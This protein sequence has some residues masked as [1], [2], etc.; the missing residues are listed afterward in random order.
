MNRGRAF[1]FGLSF[2]GGFVVP[3]SA[4]A[5]TTSSI[6][7]NNA[8]QVAAFQAG[9]TVVNF[10][11]LPGALAATSYAGVDGTPSTGHTVSNPVAG[12]FFNSGGAT[13]LNPTANPGTPVGLLELQGGIASDA[14]SPANVIV[15]L[16]VVEPHDIKIFTGFMEVAHQP[17]VG[18]VGFWVNPSLGP[19]TVFLSREDPANPGFLQQIP[20]SFDGD[21]GNFIGISLD[22]NIIANV[23]IQ[24]RSGAPVN[25]IGIDDYTFGPAAVPEPSGLILLGAGCFGLLVRGRR[26]R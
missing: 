19:I 6:N 8:A 23:S 15:P 25:G 4:E 14:H 24:H 26:A 1:L 20:G 13:A 11:A 18:R 21:P 7:T 22:E 9:A 17:F 5:L 12:V 10:D 2:A 3:W 16:D